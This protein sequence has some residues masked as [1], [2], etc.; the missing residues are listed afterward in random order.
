MQHRLTRWSEGVAAAEPILD[1][2]HSKVWNCALTAGIRIDQYRVELETCPGLP[3]RQRSR[4]NTRRKY[5]PGNHR[6]QSSGLSL[7]TREDS[8]KGLLA[9]VDVIAPLGGDGG[10]EQEHS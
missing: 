9:K 8:S 7:L 3:S 6:A 4:P 10:Y 5:C 1:E 2:M